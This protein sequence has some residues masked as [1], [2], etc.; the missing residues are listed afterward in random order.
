MKTLNTFLEGLLNRNNKVK[1]MDIS[2]IDIGNPEDLKIVL[3]DHKEYPG[4]AVFT[5]SDGLCLIR[6]R[7]YGN[8]YGMPVFEFFVEIDGVLYDFFVYISVLRRDKKRIN[9]E[10]IPI[11]EHTFMKFINSGYLWIV[12]MAQAK[13]FIQDQVK[14]H[15]EIHV[16]DEDDVS[17][18]NLKLFKKW[19][20]IDFRVK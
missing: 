17:A 10:I 5:P 2:D 20:E 3:P 13:K 6:G 7:K 1:T 16:D 18:A 9:L 19:L 11:E 4:N 12:D 14:F 15:E 8:K